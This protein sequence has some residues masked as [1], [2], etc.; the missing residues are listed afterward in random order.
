MLASLCAFSS[1]WRSAW[2]I[3]FAGIGFMIGILGAIVDVSFGNK[4]W[5]VCLPGP[6]VYIHIIPCIMLLF[7]F[8]Y[9]CL[10]MEKDPGRPTRRGSP[11]GTPGDDPDPVNRSEPLA[12]QIALQPMQ[13]SEPP[14]RFRAKTS[15]SKESLPWAPPSTVVWKKPKLFSSWRGWMRKGG[16]RE[17]GGGSGSR[18]EMRCR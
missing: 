11:R 10:F 14:G 17:K 6:A 8:I 1:Q 15:Q 7:L 12:S 13:E 4:S 3:S 16:H 9:S 2:T 5:P 18:P